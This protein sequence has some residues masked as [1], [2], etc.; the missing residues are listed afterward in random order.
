[1]TYR[2]FFL[3][4]LLFL[5]S[6]LFFHKILISSESL[7]YSF[8][9]KHQY[10]PWK[11]MVFKIIRNYKE[12]PLWNPYTFSGSPFIGNPLVFIFHPLNIIYYFFG[13][14]CFN[15]NFLLY[16]FLSGFFLYIFLRYLGLKS[17]S[18]FI[19]AIIYMFSTTLTIRIFSGHF[20]AIGVM[21]ILPLEFLVLEMSIRKN[22]IMNWLLFSILLSFSFLLGHLEYILYS[23]IGLFSYFIFRVTILKKNTGKN[24]N[25]I[26]FTISVFFSVLLVSFQIIPIL[27]LSRYSVRG[28]NNLGFSSS[29][30]MPPYFPI[31]FIL[32]NFFGSSVNGSFWAPIVEWEVSAY[33]GIIPL[34]LSFL[35]LILGKSS[36]R[37]FFGFLIIFSILFSFG[38]YGFLFPLLF[39]IIPIFRFFRKPVAIIFL[40]TFSISCL[41][42]IGF[43][44]LIRKRRLL[45]SSKKNRIISELLF[46]V[47]IIT[48]IVIVAFILCKNYIIDIASDVAMERLSKMSLP[49][50]RMDT[51]VSNSNIIIESIY[52]GILGDLFLILVIN[53]FLVIF[54]IFGL[55]KGKIMFMFLVFLIVLNLWIYS[56]NYIQLDSKK[57]DN[58]LVSFLKQDSSLFRIFVFDNVKIEGL[59]FKGSEYIPDYLAYNYFGK[60]GIETVWGYD[61]TKLL[62]Y[63]EL[64]SKISNNTFGGP[65]SRIIIDEIKNPQILDLLNVK[66]IVTSEKLLDER[67]ELK[68]NESG[69]LIYENKYW[70]P[71]IF[72]VH[73]KIVSNKPLENICKNDF[74]PS[75]T[76]IFEEENGM[77]FNKGTD[78]LTIIEYSPNKIK[79]VVNTTS[80]GFLIFSQPYYPGWD[81][82]DNGRKVEVHVANHAL[83]GI[84]IGSGSHLV[85]FVYKPK[86]FKIGLLVSLFSWSLVSVLLLL[87]INKLRT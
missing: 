46:L 16:N 31:S 70:L 57:M 32:P 50:S 17:E 82:Y 4:G 67:Y 56:I 73:K 29:F 15:Y 52:S 42:G 26:F 75:E 1:M 24:N 78:D 84:N 69:S 7:I 71:R 28:E 21:T 53:L 37:W 45:S 35:S 66:Y 20:G 12:F 44:N 19:S 58:E 62:K 65:E 36:Y 39:K 40:Y 33:V 18:S 60:F 76:V 48:F 86:S 54:L 49:E 68:L 3:I 38:K 77:G 9:V 55:S 5:L 41:S 14:I 72:P 63:T 30:S 13:E 83:M 10:W 85:E 27:E 6:I 80:S 51:L 64:F 74:S 25:I 8:D 43:D 61:S 59:E 47:T 79:I 87:I 22:K 11:S 23:L 81:A 34:Y 2:D